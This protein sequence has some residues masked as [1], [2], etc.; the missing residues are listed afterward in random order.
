MSVLEWLFLA[1]GPLLVV[2]VVAKYFLKTFRDR[3]QTQLDRVE[4]LSARLGEQLAV[5][6]TKTELSLSSEASQKILQTLRDS[7]R[8]MKNV[9]HLGV[10]SIDPVQNSVVILSERLEKFDEKMVD[11]NDLA[12]LSLAALAV[13]YIRSH[14]GEMIRV[15]EMVKELCVSRTKL[16]SFLRQTLGCS[17]QVLVNVIKMQEAK[18]LLKS[19]DLLIKEVACRVG[20]PNP[21][22]FSVRFK[23]F[24]GVAPRFFQKHYQERKQRIDESAHPLDG[25]EIEEPTSSTIE[26]V[27]CEDGQN[28]QKEEKHE[29]SSGVLTEGTKVDRF[30]I[31]G[32]IG[33]GGMG[34]VYKAYDPKLNRGVA[35]KLIRADHA[36]SDHSKNR[37]LREAQAL[38]RL[39][40]PNVLH[41]YDVGTF[42]DQVF[43]AMALVEGQT[44]KNWLKT[45]KRSVDEKLRVL[46]AAGN[47]LSAAHKAGLVHRDFKPSNVIVGDDEH[48]RV[49]DFG[50]ARAVSFADDEEDHDRK[51]KEGFSCREVIESSPGSVSNLLLTPLTHAGHILGTPLYMAP[52]QHLGVNADERSDL[53]SFSVV[54]YEALYERRPF[55]AKTLEDLQQAILQQQVRPP[56]TDTEVPDWLWQIVR[57]G[58]QVD[59]QSRHQ[60]MELLLEELRND[61]LKARRE[62]SYGRRRISFLVLVITLAII[63]P[64]GVWSG[65]RYRTVQLCKAAKSELSGVWDK[66]MKTTVQISILNTK[67]TFSKE[68]WDRLEK[69]LDQYIADWNQMRSD[70]C[71]ARWLH[72]SESEELFDLR[73]ACLR[74][75]LREFE[76]LVNVLTTANAG[77][78]EKAIQASSS[79]PK[80]EVCADNEALT[81]RIE[82]PRDIATQKMV[83]VTR[84]Q[85]T[86]ADALSRTGQYQQGLR[87]A[88]SGIQRANQSRYIPLQAEAL[89]CFAKIEENL[90]HYEHSAKN[91]HKALWLAVQVGHDRVAAQTANHLLRLVGY[92]LDQQK[93]I[94]QLADRSASFIKRI[95]SPEDLLSDWHGNMGMALFNRSDWTGALIHF[96]K[97]MEVQ[98]NLYGPV[99]LKIA[100]S[101]TRLGAVKRNLGDLE[102]AI[103]FHRKAL[104]MR[105]RILGKMHSMVAAC[106]TNIGNVYRDMKNYELAIEHQR[107][108]IAILEETVGPKHPILSAGIHNMAMAYM[109]LGKPQQAVEFYSRAVQIRKESLGEKHQDFAMSLIG[110][111]TALAEMGD[112]T[113]A[114]IHVHKGHEIISERFGAE[115]QLVTHPL[116]AEA[117][118]FIKQGKL[119]NADSILK[120]ATKICQ[121]SFCPPTTVADLTHLKYELARKIWDTKRSKKKAMSLMREVILAYQKLGHRKEIDA[122]RWL[123]EK[124]KTVSN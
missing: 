68:T 28:D 27:N 103:E 39:S 50:L 100:A 47:G 31:V 114:S 49:L 5:E 94:E 29:Q 64:I 109:S 80:I 1:S 22:H 90:G 83:E 89:M 52:E 66:E 123:Q 84:A 96:M 41:V 87:F 86:R 34:V 67:K 24:F 36:Q 104:N 21:Y 93:K 105:Q 77:V 51:T 108:S 59:L 92:R 10:S 117:A 9:E 46:I 13:I 95:G 12:S 113:Q 99:H 6:S 30:L 69:I 44:L 33:R 75:N 102:S 40:H 119:T 16:N 2:G 111:G 23:L 54:L 19:G 61:P 122:R 97:A 55:H 81:A 70:V 112:Y 53:F 4:K 32:L 106:H 60:S 110:L 78:V 26:S 20:Y 63:L 71:E 62:R 74:K 88:Q 42:G 48:V 45:K 118:I 11:E 18:T 3:N 17:A 85:L 7:Q 35:L 121:E 120:R 43:M 73:I 8:R 116:E 124:E 107:Q 38:A 76:A 56:P 72:A 115:H 58:L 101:L 25:S 37:L 15:E 98:K 82:P 65:L 14:I 79:L 91:Y 57:K